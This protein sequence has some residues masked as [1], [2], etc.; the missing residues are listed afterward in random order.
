M[1]DKEVLVNLFQKVGCMGLLFLF[2]SCFAIRIIEMLAWAHNL[3]TWTLLL[4]GSMVA[5]V[6]DCPLS[7]PPICPHKQY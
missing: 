2:N 6:T 7:A 5:Y 4:A 3:A 1:R